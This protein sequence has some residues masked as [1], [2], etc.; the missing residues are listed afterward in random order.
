VLAHKTLWI[1]L[2]SHGMTDRSRISTNRPPIP[3]PISAMIGKRLQI[4]RLRDFRR[5]MLAYQA[6]SFVKD[7]ASL[8]IAATVEFPVTGC[9]LRGMIRSIVLSIQLNAAPSI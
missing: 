1:A 9:E 3:P 8:P 6:H 7:G 2:Y 4:V 5:I